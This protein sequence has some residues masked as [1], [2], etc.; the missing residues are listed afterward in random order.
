M[1]VEKAD[2]AIVGASAAGLAAALAAARAGADVLLLESKSDIG[3]PAA[4]AIVGFDMLWPAAIPRPAYT[5]RRRLGGLTLRAS[6][7]RG[8]EIDA[9]LTLFDRAR[10]DAHLAAEA[11][12]AGA[13]I[14]TGLAD[15]RVRDD[16]R[17]VAAGFE[18]Q[19]DVL[20]FA[21]GARTQAARFLRPTRDPEELAW[22][23]ILDLEAPGDGDRLALTLG[24]HAPGGRSQLNPLG[25]GH[26]SHW[27]FFRGDVAA[28]EAV[29]RHAL[30][31]DARIQGWREGDVRAR[32]AGVAPDPVYTLPRE[33]ARGNVL[34]AGGAAGQGGLEV[35]LASGWMAGE[36]AA[37]GDLAGYARAWRKRYQGGYERLRTVTDM[38]TRLTDDET[39]ALLGAWDARRLAAPPTPRALLRAGGAR[40]FAAGARAALVAWARG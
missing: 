4:P 2:L 38:L 35:G 30:A 17:L 21:D 39:R 24:P 16:K 15:L 33:L 5:V 11:E 40:G 14:V 6:D 31:V 22:G 3:A 29:A 19:A 1:A 12:K 20:L 13:R 32:F 9:P 7:G 18:A 28:A 37:R 10:F 25:E 26:W 34:V 23:A 36:A 27:T 8:P